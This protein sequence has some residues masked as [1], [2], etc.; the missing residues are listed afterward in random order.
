MLFAYDFS[1]IR[2]TIMKRRLPLELSHL[3]ASPLAQSIGPFPHLPYTVAGIDGFEHINHLFPPGKTF[4][5]LRQSTV[6]VLPAKYRSWYL[7]LQR[8]CRMEDVEC[9]TLPAG[10]A[11]VEKRVEDA[12]DT[13]FLISTAVKNPLDHSALASALSIETLA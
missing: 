11:F 1:A 8:M 9:A 2:V 12:A 3:S 10:K 5:L 7:G 4:H 13:Y 6:W